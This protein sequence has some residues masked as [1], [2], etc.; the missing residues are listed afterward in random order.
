M[1]L[2]RAAICLAQKVGARLGRG[3]AL[4]R[5]LPAAEEI[6]RVRGRMMQIA[7]IGPAW[8]G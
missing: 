2:L 3:E 5:T 7:V 8:R 4:F 6:I 1:R